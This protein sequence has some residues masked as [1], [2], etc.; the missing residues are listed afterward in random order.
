P[1]SPGPAPAPPPARA[2]DRRDLLPEARLDP[3][4][5]LQT[6]ERLLRGLELVHLAVR[7]ADRHPV[8]IPVD[9]HDLALDL[10]RRRGA[11]LPGGRRRRLGERRT[12]PEQGRDD[13]RRTELLP[14]LHRV[15]L[16]LGATS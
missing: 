15:L 5:F 9:L 8:R 1:G 16:S 3:I 2:G 14:A 11:A 12:A 6:L 10:L 4:A 7:A 13:D